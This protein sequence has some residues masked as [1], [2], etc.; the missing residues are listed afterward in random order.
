MFDFM[1]WAFI[2]F[3]FGL[4]TPS[5][6]V[7]GYHWLAFLNQVG[8][9]TVENTVVPSP[10][11]TG[12]FDYFD[13]ISKTKNCKILEFASAF[14]SEQCVSFM[15]KNNIFG[16]LLR[17]KYSEDSVIFE[18]KIY[19]ISKNKNRKERK[20]MFHSFQ[21][22]AHLSCKYRHFWGDGGR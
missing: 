12:N 13:R 10:Q 21:H 19:D 14:V 16:R 7:I 17:S 20:L 22:I 3:T 8:K 5:Q 2:I 9:Q 11:F 1:I 4:N 15:I 18:Y 6:L